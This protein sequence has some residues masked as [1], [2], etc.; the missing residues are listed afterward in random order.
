MAGVHHSTNLS[1]W[2]QTAPLARFSD[3]GAFPSIDQAVPFKQPDQQQT[4]PDA[5]LALGLGNRLKIEHS[6][7]YT[8]P[9]SHCFCVEAA[10]YPLAQ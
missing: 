2:A 1:S 5:V 9:T 8:R 4:S 7:W 10:C 3:S 6:G